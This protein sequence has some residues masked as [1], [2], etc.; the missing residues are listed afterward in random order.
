M[1]F[2]NDDVSRSK[3]RKN[4]VEFLGLMLLPLINQKRK[5]MIIL[6]FEVNIGY[7]DLFKLILKLIILSLTFLDLN[8]IR[9]IM[10]G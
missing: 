5:I 4:Y 3:S 9:L 6:I 2:K 7:P 8:L 1:L 10:V